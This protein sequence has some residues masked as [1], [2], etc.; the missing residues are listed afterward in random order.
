MTDSKHTVLF[1]DQYGDIGGGQRI[2]LDLVSG[3]RSRGLE[4]RLL[5][6][7]GPLAE[8]AARRGARVYPLSLPHVQSGR[9]T[10]RNYVRMWFFSRRVAREHQAAAEGCH[11]LVVNGL[12]LLMVARVWGERFALPTVLYLHGVHHGIAQWLIASFLRRPRTAAIAP[13]P[14]VA[15]PFIHLSNVHEIANWVAPEFLSSPRDSLTLRRSLAITDEDPIVLVPGRLSVTK[16]QLLILQALAL[17]HDV[18]AHFVFAG[19]PLFEERGSDVETAIRRATDLEPGRVPLT[20]W[21]QPL[22]A[23][24]DGA[25]LVIVPSVWQEPFGLVAL[26]AMA[27]SRP[28]IV[29]DRGMLPRL[30]G[31]GRFAEV[32]PATV[33]GIAG[34][35]RC[36]LQ[37]PSTCVRRAMGGRAQVEDAYHPARQMEKVFALFDRLCHT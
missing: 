26:E 20:H 37:D 33:E 34:A 9:K 23:L 29:T 36:C 17:L 6:P 15:A 25:D 27:R 19:A 22:P 12:R 2:L 4:V 5:C 35:I 14:F 1:L 21:E 30:A 10:L 16:G 28:L 24:F 13:S 7:V 11:L 32:V 18:R 3:A 31:D 8:E